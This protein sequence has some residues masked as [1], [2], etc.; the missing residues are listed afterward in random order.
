[1]PHAPIDLGTLAWGKGQ[2]EKGGLSPGSDGPDIGFDQGI[3]AV[4]A[5][6]AQTLEHLGR[7]IGIALQHLDDLPFERI[8]FAGA[9]LRLARAEVVLGQPVGHGA[10]SQG[11]FPGDL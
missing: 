7:R 2:G 5:L 4:K 8:E 1:M 9:L 11:E 3:A 10:G 6:L